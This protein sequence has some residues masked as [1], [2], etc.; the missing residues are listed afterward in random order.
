LKELRQLRLGVNIDHVA[1]LRQ[2][3]GGVEPEPVF[4][5]GIAERAG[6]HG[7]TVHLREDRRHIQDRDLELLR[8]V[9]T[10]SLNL[11]MAAVASIVKIALKVRPDQV[12]LVPEKRKELTTE[13]GLAV[14]S[15]QRRLRSIV[16]Q[17]QDRKIAVSLF[18][19]PEEK[20]IA[21]ASAIGADFIELHTGSYAGVNVRRRERELKRLRR[22]VA[23]ALACGLRV[24]AGHGLNYHNVSAVA[25][26]PGMEELNIGHSIISRAVFVGLGQAVRE[27]VEILERV[28][29]KGG[30]EVGRR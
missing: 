6:A 17:L 22:G 15:Q 21:A 5:A 27:M 29:L 30:T 24:N 18:I 3:R 11:E 26:L 16:R 28:K 7:I 23:Q 13:G 1:T 2:A 20:E 8:E 25:A 14:A 9:V 19:D 10:T 12:T 4:A